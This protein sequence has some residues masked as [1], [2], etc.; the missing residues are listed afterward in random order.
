MILE[1][2]TIKNFS[3]QTCHNQWM[4]PKGEIGLVTVIIMTY[5]RVYVLGETIESV[6]SQTYRPIEL[7][8][9]DDGSTDNTQLI[10]EET[11]NKHKKDQNIK[12]RYLRQD[13]HG[14]P[15]ARNLA[16]INC[17]GEYIQFLGSDDLLDSEKIRK[18]MI[19]ASRYPETILCG[20]WMYFWEENG[21][22]V[23]ERGEEI[24]LNEDII[25]Q[26]L[27]G[28]FFIEIAFLW[29]R[30]LIY[31]IG[32]W[33][34]SLVREQDGDYFL[35]AV[36]QKMKFS[37]VPETFSYWRIL[38]SGCPSISTTPS[39]DA[40]MS[41]IRVVQKLRF[42]LEDRGEFSQNHRNAMGQWFKSAA[43]AYVGVAPEISEWCFQEY[44]SL[45][46]D[47]WIPR[48]LLS[49]FVMRTFGLQPKRNFYN[50]K[51]EIAAK[52]RWQEFNTLRKD[53]FAGR[54]FIS[55]ITLSLIH[56]IWMINN[57]PRKLCRKLLIFK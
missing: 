46:D 48:N 23:K 34:E 2:Q 50:L 16:L 15:A 39:S 43:I 45:S 3:S 1:E 27:K 17:H 29:P 28:K 11:V 25:L 37:Y 53:H 14:A 51:L 56:P 31:H 32:P 6:V 7:I 10:V 47:R 42:V 54:A 36:L 19:V 49:Y 41:R 30:N 55:L 40:L 22:Y 12:I 4:N 52:M 13:H 9:V 26:W 24:N 35:R 20:P 5:N 18:Q 57:L 33:D 8:V 21:Q 38:P 44:R